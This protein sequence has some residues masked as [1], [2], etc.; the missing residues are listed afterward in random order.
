MT[1][2]EVR[3]LGRAE[4]LELLAAQTEQCERLT[5]K[6]ARA[7]EALASRRIAIENA[8]SLAEAALALNGVFQSAQEA[9]EQYLENLRLRSENQEQQLQEAEAQ[10]RQRAEQILREAR[11]QAEQIRAEA[12]EYSRSL[13]ETADRYWSDAL[14]RP[15]SEE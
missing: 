1:D 5:S 4:L 10:A 13:H 7:E 8:G 12:E 9:A 15:M 14:T 11:E 2:K 6:L 3:R